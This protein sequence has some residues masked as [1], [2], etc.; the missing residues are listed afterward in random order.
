[1]KIKQQPDGILI[2][3]QSDA[4]KTILASWFQV[5][6]EKK[7]MTFGAISLPPDERPHA[8][9]ISVG[10]ESIKNVMSLITAGFDIEI[11]G[12]SGRRDG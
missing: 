12:P 4:E 8:I 1:M 7:A 10:Q 5:Y 6:T 3:P 2:E 11:H 9:Y